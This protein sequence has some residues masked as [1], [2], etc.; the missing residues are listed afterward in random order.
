GTKANERIWHFKRD[1]TIDQAVQTAGLKMAADFCTAAV[2]INGQTVLTV[3]PYSPTQEL[4]VTAHLRQ[5]KNEVG[6]TTMSVAG[7]AAVALSITLVDKDGKSTMIATDET[8]QGAVSLGEV[9]PELW[10]LGRR[11]ATISPFDNYEQWQQAKGDSP[12]KLPQFWTAPGF[13]VTR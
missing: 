3:E 10:G 7:P 11:S 13:E 12:D 6:I 5:G 9:Q 4:D 1:F 8:W 2:V